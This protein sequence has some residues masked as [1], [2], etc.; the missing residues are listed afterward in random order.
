MR[1]VYLFAAVLWTALNVEGKFSK[2]S[3]NHVGEYGSYSNPNARAFDKCTAQELI[4][5]S[6]CCNDVLIKLN[7]CKAED[8]ACECCALQSIDKECYSLCPGNPSVNFLTVLINDCSS[9][10]GVNACGLPFKKYDEPVQT[11]TVNE[12]HLPKSSDTTAQITATSKVVP[13]ISTTDVVSKI[14]GESPTQNL[15][16]ANASSLSNQ[17]DIIVA[18]RA[19]LLRTK[20]TWLMIFATLFVMV[21]NLELG[22]VV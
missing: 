1:L 18:S 4:K 9:L 8:L 7:T 22:I 11:Y 6:Q 5:L 16:F 10:Q 17:S 14:I 21:L 19:T 15:T 2:Q 13:V 12:N 3:S 20:C